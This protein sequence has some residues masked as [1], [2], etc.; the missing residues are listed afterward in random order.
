MLDVLSLPPAR[1]L[2][3]EKKIYIYRYTRP[4][5]HFAVVA[6]PV[7][8]CSAQARMAMSQCCTRSQLCNRLGSAVRGATECT[9]ALTVYCLLV[10]HVF[11]AN[12]LSSA[13][14]KQ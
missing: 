1:A 9:E 13:L 3:K 4:D 5:V 11:V 6:S 12:A 14:C 8:F 7:R 2:R 10:E